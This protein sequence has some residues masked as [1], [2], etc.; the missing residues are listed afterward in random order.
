MIDLHIGGL[1]EAERWL[2]ERS[3]WA[4]V[5]SLGDP[6]ERKPAGL[7][8][9][10]RSMRREFHDIDR[11]L[12]WLRGLLLPSGEDVAAILE[13]FGAL[14]RGH[15]LV[16]CHSGVGR[17]AGAAFVGLCQAYGPG[18]EADAIAAVL[19]VRPQALPN[20]RI[21]TLADQQLGRGGRMIAVVDAHLAAWKREGRARAAI[22]R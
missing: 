4:A 3:D 7:A 21:V 16:H 5:L 17:S 10:L 18:L 13:F 6:G 19:A 9:C 12:P 8:D 1:E 22:H 11:A 20:R 2:A 14:E 15:V